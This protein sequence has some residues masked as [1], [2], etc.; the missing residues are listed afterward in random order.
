MQTPL[1]DAF[2]RKLYD[3]TVGNIDLAR[4]TYTRAQRLVMGTGDE[5]ICEAVLQDAY[6]RECIFSSRSADTLNA[7]EELNQNKITA[8]A[9][10]AETS[11]KTKHRQPFIPSVD[12]PQ[13]PE[14][15]D[16]L[17]KVFNSTTLREDISNP[18]EI[19]QAKDA[20]CAV[21]YLREKQLLCE[22][23]LADRFFD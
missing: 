10:Q 4:R 9:D 16:L 23:P 6:E 14:F 21:T 15:Y 7:R 8:G 19:R 18:D 12:R 11:S 1:T 20:R 22:D 5:S 17:Q 3:L 13:H 2:S